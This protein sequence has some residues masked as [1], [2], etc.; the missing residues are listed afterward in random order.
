MSLGEPVSLRE[1]VL[2]NLH[3]AYTRTRRPVNLRVV[4]RCV[5]GILLPFLRALGVPLDE[6][7]RLPWNRGIEAVLKSIRTREISRDATQPFRQRAC[8]AHAPP[9]RAYP[10]YRTPLRRIYELLKSILTKLDPQSEIF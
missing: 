2:R 10:A 9:L 3:V 7:A 1:Y 4:G 8:R 6:L 5:A